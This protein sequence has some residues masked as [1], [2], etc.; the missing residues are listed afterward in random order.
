MKCAPAA[1]IL[2]LSTTAAAPAAAAIEGPVRVETGMVVGGATKDP[3]VTAFRG[4]PYAAPPVGPLRWRAPQ[5]PKPWDGMRPA[6][7]PGPICPQPAGQGGAVR[8]ISEDCLNLDVW[9]A[10]KGAGENRPVMVWFHGGGDG[11]GAGS[12]PQYDGEGLAKK[13]AVVV[14]VNFRG[15]PMSQFA[16]PELSKESGHGSGAYGLLDDFAALKWVQAN[17]A[18]FGG[19]PRNVTI[20]GQSFGAGT[21]QFLTASPLA[22]GLFQKVI[23][24]S[25]AR[26]ERDPEPHTSGYRTLKQAE[27]EGVKFQVAVGATSLADLRAMSWQD[28]IKAYQADVAARGTRGVS[29]TYIQDGYVFPRSFAQIYASGAQADVAVIA[30]DNRDETGSSPDSA[31]DLMTAG[32]RPR[33]NFP[34]VHTV[35]EYTAESRE[36]FGPMAAE[37]FRLYPATSD[38]EAFLASSAVARDSSR[39]ST[40]LWAVSW[41]KKISKPVYLYY[42]THAPPGPN[43]GLTGAAH[44]SEIAYVYNR[45]GAAWTDEDRQIGDRMSSYWVNFARTGDPNGP[46]LP[47]WPAFDGKTEQAMELGQGFKPIPITDKARA[48][49]WR[50][51]YASQPAN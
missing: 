38:R 37:L 47:A 46:G 21:E 39:F 35:G 14:T 22:K 13:G 32:D 25:H 33:V 20:F 27:A 45:P 18:A 6:D 1:L 9:T 12:S 42:W 3:A 51:F 30:G 48:G 36:K 10:A 16:H 50:R 28:V 34:A 31:Y 40:W 4:L 29:W 49:F 43:R 8:N 23:F 17:I 11:F 41:K 15:G 5:P 7:K 19:D 2:I 44:G 26:Y 24:E